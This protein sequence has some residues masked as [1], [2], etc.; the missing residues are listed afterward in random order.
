MNIRTFIF[1]LGGVI[2]DLDESKT[3]SQ[4]ARLSGRS[5][6]EVQ[7]LPNQSELFKNFEKG[8]IPDHEFRN[9]L[10]ELL[11]AAMSDQQIDDAWNVMLGDMPVDRLHLLNH[12]RKDH[13]V[14]Y[15]HIAKHGIPGIGR[16]SNRRT[17][18]TP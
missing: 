15:R 2:I 1:D 14:V 17:A 7:D 13:Q 9:G 11:N 8:L 16:P 10:R 4:L 3:F 5:F 6:Q 12:L 18:G